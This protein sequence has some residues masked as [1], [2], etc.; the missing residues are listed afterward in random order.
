M[1]RFSGISLVTVALALASPSS[2]R[3]ECVGLCISTGMGA[4]LGAAVPVLVTVPIAADLAS[5]STAHRV[6][7]WAT[8]GVALLGGAA[9]W[10]AGYAIADAAEQTDPD[11][12]VFIAV[13]AWM[14]IA[15]A[16]GGTLLVWQLSPARPLARAA[17]RLS[18][19]LAPT[20]GGWSGTLAVQF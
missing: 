16:V 13:P 5:R 10:A 3:A 12:K 6:S 17:P 9:G 8:A 2:A 7:F 20:P 11:P 19:G 14:G 15:G 4:A 1:R 18:W